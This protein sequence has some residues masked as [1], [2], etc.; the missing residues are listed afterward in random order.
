MAYLKNL[1]TGHWCYMECE[2]QEHRKT[3]RGK[4]RKITRK[5]MCCRK[6]EFNLNC[7]FFPPSSFLCLLDDNA[8]EIGYKDIKDYNENGKMRNCLKWQRD[9]IEEIK[10]KKQRGLFLPGVV[11]DE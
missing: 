8:F 5:K 6:C 1:N 11:F 3:K 9:K 10:N 7:S 4:G 2:V